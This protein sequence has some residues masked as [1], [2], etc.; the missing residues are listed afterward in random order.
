MYADVR[1]AGGGEDPWRLWCARREE[2]FA[3]HPQTPLDDPSS[4][5]GIPYFPYDPQWRMVAGVELVDGG[6]LMLGH[7]GDGSTRFSKFGEVDVRGE[8]LS[9][10]WLNEYGGGIFL[11][12]RDATSGKSTYGGGRYLLDT[13]KG[14]DLGTIDGQLVLDFNYAYQPSCA[15]SH[16]WSCPLAPPENTL[17]APIEAGERY[18]EYSRS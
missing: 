11:P 9:L 7:S 8:V 6:D 14:A 10:Y 17:K 3:H 2:L 18:L 1:A 12:F 15:Y 13:V 4:F 5:S 16:R